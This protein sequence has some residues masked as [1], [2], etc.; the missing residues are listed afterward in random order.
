[1]VASF[2]EFEKFP[3]EPSPDRTGPLRIGYLSARFRD[4]SVTRAFLSW[5]RDRNRNSVNAIAY[6]ASP[7][8][9]AKTDEVR[10]AAQSSREVGAVGASAARAIRADNLDV[11]VFL[12]VG[13]EPSMTQLAALRLAPIACLAWDYPVTSGLPSID[14]FLSSALAEPAHAQD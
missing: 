7:R 10:S 14:Y 4:T 8:E 12:D 9:D 3:S 13:M 2:P 1:M 5:I 11:V 6:H